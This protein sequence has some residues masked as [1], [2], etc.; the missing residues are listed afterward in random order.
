MSDARRIRAYHEAG[1]ALLAFHVGV[2]VYAIV[3]NAKAGDLQSQTRHV[4]ESYA[5]ASSR[6]R[7]LIA[8]AGGIAEEIQFGERSPGCCTD[9]QEHFESL[10][11]RLIAEAS[12]GPASGD[13]IQADLEH[14]IRDLLRRPL[15]KALDILVNELIERPFTVGRRAFELLWAVPEV[16]PYIRVR[17]E[18]Y[19]HGSK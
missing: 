16:R 11:T 15:R 14:E 13:E 8:L 4:P 12:V 18:A 2:Q 1:H 5:K 6:A 19:E 9:D 3:V 10:R 7:A 17:P